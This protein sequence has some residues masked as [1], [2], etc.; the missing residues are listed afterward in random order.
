MPGWDPVTGLGSVDFAAFFSLFTTIKTHAN[1]DGDV[2]PT[3]PGTNQRTFAIPS[4]AMASLFASL[5]DA[6]GWIVWTLFALLVV[7]AAVVG[8]RAVIQVNER[9]EFSHFEFIF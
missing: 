9:N 5:N 8:I 2:V 7:V 4:D 6:A 3:A 1:D